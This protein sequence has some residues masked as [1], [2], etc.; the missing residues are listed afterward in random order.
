[1]YP[2]TG[3][4]IFGIRS[5]YIFNQFI[6]SEHAATVLSQKRHDFVFVLSQMDVRFVSGDQSFFKING[7]SAMVIGMEER[8]AA[9]LVLHG[10]A[11]GCPNSCQKLGIAKGF[12]YVVI[13]AQIQCKY[14]VLLLSTGRDHENGNCGPGSYFL[15]HFCSIQIWK[16]QI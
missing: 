13:S 11:E 8:I 4:V 3:V 6:I 9:C 2:E 15:N 5:P 10:M 14:L 1:M 7:Q 12:C 16:S